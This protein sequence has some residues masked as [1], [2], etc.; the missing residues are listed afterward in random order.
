MLISELLRRCCFFLCFN[1]RS[2]SG[3]AGTDDRSA[4]IVGKRTSMT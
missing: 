2:G 4:K 1:V 3:A